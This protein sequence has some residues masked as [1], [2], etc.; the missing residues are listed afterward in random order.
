MCLWVGHMKVPCYTGE[1]QLAGVN[2]LLY[3]VGGRDRTQI[4]RQVPFRIF[5]QPQKIS[6]Y[7]C[8]HSYYRQPTN[9][10]LDTSHNW[11]HRI[12]GLFHLASFTEHV[13]KF[14][15]HLPML[16]VSTTVDGYVR[17]WSSTYQTS[18]VSLLG[19]YCWLLKS[20]T[21]GFAWEVCFHFCWV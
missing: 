6:S 9:L 18:L 19:Y 14:Y 8:S 11:I 10:F 21:W 16:P 13:F 1:G 5:H 7:G 2:S 4:T 3:C 15:P 12:H 17:F 20:C